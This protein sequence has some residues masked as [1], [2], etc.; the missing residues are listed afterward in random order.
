MPLPAPHAK[1]AAKA[2]VAYLACGLIE[3]PSQLR[4]SCL[5]NLDTLCLAKQLWLTRWTAEQA[6]EAEGTQSPLQK[7][8]TSCPGLPSPRR[9]VT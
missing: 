8:L 6:T 2:R 1:D 3:D 4:V 7:Q 9:Q 5:G